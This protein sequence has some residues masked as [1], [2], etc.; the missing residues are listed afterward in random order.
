M[1]N[2]NYFPEPVNVIVKK[3]LIMFSNLY[4]S[5]KKHVS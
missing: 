2:N 1:N 4:L 3:K 5:L